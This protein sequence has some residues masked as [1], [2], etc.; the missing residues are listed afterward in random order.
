MSHDFDI[1]REVNGSQPSVDD[2][3]VVAQT[4]Y[5]E[6]VTT[7]G[8]ALKEEEIDELLDERGTEL[9]Y[10][11]RT[12]LDNLCS[13]PITTRFFPSGSKYVPISERRDEIIFGEIDETLRVDQTALLDHV[14]DD[15]P[16][17]EEKVPIITDGRGPT[18]REVIADDAGI[19]P[20]NVEHYL[21]SGESTT[22]RERLNEAIDA[23]VAAEDVTKR[24]TYGKIVF[25][26]KAYRY[27][28]I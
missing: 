1:I 18:V 12:S 9:E 19:P 20:E 25:R 21:R 26:H 11:L 23:I 6:G 28:L 8:D 16:D 3:V 10:A 5:D 15:D 13:I 14:R 24:D 22:Q 27:H 4:L 2:Q 7:Q 17:E